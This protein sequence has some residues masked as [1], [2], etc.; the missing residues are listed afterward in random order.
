MVGGQ[1]RGEIGASE[2]AAVLISEPSTNSWFR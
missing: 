2:G 1:G